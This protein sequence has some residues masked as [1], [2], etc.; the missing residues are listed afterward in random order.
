[1]RLYFTA[2]RF[3]SEPTR[4]Q[5]G[6]GCPRWGLQS[7]WA[8]HSVA[9]TAALVGSTSF[10]IGADDYRKLFNS[11]VGEDFST[12]DI[13][14]A[15]DRIWNLERV[16]NLSVGIDPSQ[17]TLP[18]RLLSEPMPA[19]PTK[20]HV[21]RLAEMLGQYYAERGWSEQGVPTQEKL[22]DLQIA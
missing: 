6:S 11:I 16:Y 2:P 13:M 19:G 5:T 18:K 7:L 15:G 12:E 10:A 17:D 22:A 8:G 9:P 1:M 14:N 4:R 20:G 21:H 3:S